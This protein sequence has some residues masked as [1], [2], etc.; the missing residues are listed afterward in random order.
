MNLAPQPLLERSRSRFRICPNLLPPLAAALLCASLP[1]SARADEGGA[2]DARW[3]F[4]P[5][6]TSQLPRDVGIPQLASPFEIEL[7]AQGTSVLSN[8]DASTLFETRHSSEPVKLNTDEMSRLLRSVGQAARHLALGE[9][10]QAQQAMEGVYSLSG[11]AR[12]Y[13]NRE[14]ARARKIFDTCLMTAYLW[15]RDQKHA[16]ALRQMLEC[17]RSFPGFR[18]DSVSYP[19]E[20]RKVFEQAKLQLNQMPATSLLVQSKQSGACGVRLNG[21]ELG[22]SPMSFTDVRAGIT[23]VQLECQPGV[24]GRIHA[25]E[26][27]PGENRLDIDPV[28]DAS[29]HSQSALWLQYANDS[30][31]TQRVDADLAQIQ[32]ALGSPQVVGLLIDGAASYPRVRVRPL[33]KT[34]KEI[35]T[36]SYSLGEGYSPQAVS[37]AIKQLRGRREDS[38]RKPREAPARSVDTSGE[39]K[40]TAHEDPDRNTDDPFGDPRKPEP[41]PELPK[42]VWN[43]RD[44]ALGLVLAAAGV[45]GIATGW[46]LYSLHFDFVVGQVKRIDATLSGERLDFPAV[47]DPPVAGALL[48]AGLGNLV[49]GLSEYFWLPNAENVPVAAWVAGGL[50]VAVALASLAVAL[51][52]PHCNEAQLDNPE[53]GAGY[54]VSCRE[55]LGLPSFPALLATHALPLL[56]APIAYAIRSA[57]RPSGVQVA[58]HVRPLSNGFALQ[59]HGAF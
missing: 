33:S 46:V 32:R 41:V 54:P 12:D 44:L 57:T 28:F 20:L 10:P 11:P 4:I 59:I 2:R 36:L 31:R 5:V 7:R 14:A 52:T 43:D 50:G 15:E 25:I 53:Q 19:P 58:W 22:K 23:R 16:Q 30:E 40:A 51:F 26:L 38:T 18:P 9:L 37:E 29:V 1:A 27:K 3:L 56:A 45:G 17:S 49:L 35:A 55:Y 47:S 21:I 24:A 8:P 13:L 39:P 42:P 6:F 48:A 34:P